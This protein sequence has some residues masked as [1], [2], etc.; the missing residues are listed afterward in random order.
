MYLKKNVIFF[1]NFLFKL[2]KKNSKCIFHVLFFFFVFFQVWSRSLRAK[3]TAGD[4]WKRTLIWS[5]SKPPPYYDYYY[6]YYDYHFFWRSKSK[7][8]RDRWRSFIYQKIR[9]LKAYKRY[10]RHFQLFIS[11]IDF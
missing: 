2:L 8:I 11:F 9:L 1:L 4:A 7:E 5:G 6:Y 10:R 3:G